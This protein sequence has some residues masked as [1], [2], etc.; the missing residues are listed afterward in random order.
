MELIFE[1]ESMEESLDMGI[2]SFATKNGIVPTSASLGPEGYRELRRNLGYLAPSD[3][4]DFKLVRYTE[5][6]PFLINIIFDEAVS[7]RAIRLS[8]AVTFIKGSL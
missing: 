4:I 5:Q 6:G 3:S 1:N 2:S 8:R 7:G